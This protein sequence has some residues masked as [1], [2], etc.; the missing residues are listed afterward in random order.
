M[1]VVSWRDD[2]QT[3]VVMPQGLKRM[4]TEDVLPTILKGDFWLIDGQHS[5]EAAKKIKLMTDGVS[6]K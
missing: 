1:L 3:I 4:P 2:M 6:L 5:V